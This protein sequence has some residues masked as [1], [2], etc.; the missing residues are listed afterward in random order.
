MNSLSEKRPNQI[1][2]PIS[3]N[4][5]HG[6][7][8]QFLVKLFN[9]NNEKDIIEK[10]IES[11]TLGINLSKPKI[12][13]ILNING[14]LNRLTGN[15]NQAE[16][17]IEKY[18]KQ[19]AVHFNS[20]FT[21]K[22]DIIIAYLGF[23]EFAILKT[24]TVNEEE[25]FKKIF[26]QSAQLIF[27]PL[28]NNIEN[29]ISIGFGHAYTETRGVREAYRE[30]RMALT[31]GEKIL[32]KPESCYYFDDLKEFRIIAEDNNQKKETYAE[33]VLRGLSNKNLSLTL[34]VFFEEELNVSNAASR[35]R[36]HPNTILYRLNR[37]KQIIN[38][39]PR[40]F[41]EASTIK[42]AMMTKKVFS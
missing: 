22:K 36:V 33:E 29:G 40:R 5:S 17:L 19:I 37:I 26:K 15:Q 18:K 2:G 4:Y 9:T 35:L 25:N 6:L 32:G 38:L 3:F 12:V 23:E 24:I 31:L 28:L 39:D 34:E 13:V 16:E 8:D 20:F 1:S 10:E 21:L 7:I 27:S 11:K 30:A 41:N 42:I 14:F